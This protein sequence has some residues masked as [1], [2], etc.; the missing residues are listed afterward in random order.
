MSKKVLSRAQGVEAACILFTLNTERTQVDQLAANIAE[1][2]LEIND[3]GFFRREWYGFVHAAVVAGLMVHAPN[4]VL[5]DYLRSTSALLKEH[6]IPK[7]EAKHF[8]DTHFSPYM[9]MLGKGE[10]QNCPR[11]FFKALFNIESLEQV[12]ARALALVSA[13]MAMLLSAVTDKFEQYQIESD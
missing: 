8:V 9:E 11:Q 13:T 2:G 10:Q 3:S 4:A 7:S 5:V 6:G 1:S 12:P